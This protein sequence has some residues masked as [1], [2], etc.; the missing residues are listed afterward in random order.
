VNYVRGAASATQSARAA[1]ERERA[2]VEK[3][4]AEGRALAQT[5][6]QLRERNAR[7][8]AKLTEERERLQDKRATLTQTL[9]DIEAAQI[10]AD[11][12]IKEA[13]DNATLI[14]ELAFDQARALAERTYRHGS[15]KGKDYARAQ[16]ATLNKVL[17]TLMRR[18]RQAGVTTDERGLQ[19]KVAA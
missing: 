8:E 16:H 4:Y 12:A 18:T 9:V 7:I 6:K 11:T 14:R 3:L 15:D 13:E 17:P 19:P 5:S 1:V 2:E 10:E